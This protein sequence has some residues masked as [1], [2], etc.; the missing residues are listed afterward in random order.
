MMTVSSR[1]KTGSNYLLYEILL[2]YAAG[3]LNS[4][5]AGRVERMSAGQRSLAERVICA[6]HLRLFSRPI[7][8]REALQLFK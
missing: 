8:A 3:S 5:R 7:G 1:Q 6:I 2:G 4:N